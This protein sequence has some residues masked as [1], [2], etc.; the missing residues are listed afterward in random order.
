M[1]VVSSKNTV[2][3]E[4]GLSRNARLDRL[5]FNAAHRKLLVASGIGWAFDAMDVGLVSFVV[6]AIAADPHFNLN[7]TEK[8]WV[9]SIGFVGMAIGAAL[10]GCFADR[11]GRKTVFTATLVIFGLANAGMACSWTLTAL[12]IAR[13]IIGLGLGA[14][15]PVAS[16]LVSE[17]SPTRHRGRMTVLLE[18]FWAVGWIIAAA[19]GAFVIPNTGDW[20]WRWA[21]LIGALPL[22]YAVVTRA[23]I[24]ESVRF[25]ESKG[26]EDEAEQAVRYFEQ[27]S[28]VAPVAS[29]KAE[30]L[31]AI[32]T[33]E[34][35]G[36]QYLAR[37]VA[38]W[39]TWFFVNFSYYGAFTWMPSLLA[40]QFGSLTSSFGYTLIISLA[41]LPG[42]FLAA[43]LVEIWGRRRTLS[44]FLAVS[45]VAAFAFSQA[46]SVAA[47]I[48]FG[49]LLSA[50][51]LGA[52]GVLYAVTPEI[53][54][55]RLRGAASGAAA[56]VGR[57]AAIIAPLLVPWFLT[58]SGGNKTVA[59]VIFAVAFVLGCIAALCLPERKGLDLED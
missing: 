54:P 10:G 27:A 5:P 56:A 55:T 21:L 16:T 18:S 37:T 26:R 24:P 57:V 19:I 40:D 38:I 3:T 17:F 29:P 6:A 28:G 33:R 1:N 42:Y 53:Y 59:F 43:W 35:F 32:R 11:V 34:L 49:M 44:V 23:H 22:L 48:G 36:H 7:A 15:L 30:P 2:Q 46:G 20:G 8:S 47:V 58:L 14:E 52:W 39:L 31:P 13:F 9:L 12:L 50:S 45:A 4:R 51:N 25:L 41:Q